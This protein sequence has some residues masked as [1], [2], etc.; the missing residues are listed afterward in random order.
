M[1]RRSKK[2][3]A[4]IDARPGISMI[5]TDRTPIRPTDESYREFVRRLPCVVC[6]APTLGGDPCHLHTTRRFGDWLELDGELVGNIFPACRLHHREQH[7][8]GF[9]R[10]AGARGLDI[11]EFCKLIGRAYRLGWSTDGLGSAVLRARGYAGVDVD[12]VLDGELPC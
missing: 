1:K 8:D 5:N 9:E 4:L 2:R 6:R 12:D 7:S 10:F 3:Q 11:A